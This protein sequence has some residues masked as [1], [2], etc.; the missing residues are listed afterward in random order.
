MEF[1]LTTATQVLERTPH[2]LRALLAGLSPAWTDATEGPETWSPRM[3]VVHLIH[4]ERDNWIPRARVVLEHGASRPFPPFDRS[5]PLA[6]LADAPLA[7]LLDELV[8]LRAESLATLASWG[9]GDAELARVGHHP[10]FGEV[11]LR[12]LL[13]TWT[14]HDLAHLG[15]VSRVMAKQYRD[16]VGPWRAFLPIMDR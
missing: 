14:A 10:E 4:A 9:L 11:T 13:A 2:A 8:R 7:A 3:V 1:D 6:E 15:Q 16:A 12:Q 5:A